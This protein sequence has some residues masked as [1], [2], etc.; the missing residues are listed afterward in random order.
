MK[1]LSLNI[2]ERCIRSSLRPSQEVTIIPKL[3]SNWKN[4]E[5]LDFGRGSHSGKAL[6]KISLHCNITKLAARG[7]N[8]GSEVA[9]AI[10]NSLPKLKY[11]VLEGST[12]YK[13]EY[14]VLILL[15]CKEIVH[16]DVRNC[17]GFDKNDVE[18][19]ELASHIPAF[20]CEGSISF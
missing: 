15:G 7:T 10:V 11:L 14:L 8:V 4:L 9:S 17:I 20:M 6:A 18:I 12:F 13:Q 2:A 5:T 19:L 16:L 1:A 3:L